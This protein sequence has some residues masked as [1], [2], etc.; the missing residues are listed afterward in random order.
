VQGLQGAAERDAAAV[1]WSLIHRCLRFRFFR[2][3]GEG[4]PWERGGGSGG[5]GRVYLEE[6]EG[7][8]EQAGTASIKVLIKPLEGPCPSEL[9]RIISLAVVCLGGGCSASGGSGGSRSCALCI[10]RNVCWRMLAYADVC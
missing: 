10:V 7:E 9:E 6:E 1:G 8:K 4:L 3:R 5:G 2:Q